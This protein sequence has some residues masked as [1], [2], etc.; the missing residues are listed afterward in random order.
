MEDEQTPTMSTRDPSALEC[1]SVCPV[2]V[3][4]YNERRRR[5]KLLGCGH[6][7][8]LHCLQEIAGGSGRGAR[9]SGVLCP[10]CRQATGLPGP[11]V[12][13]LPDNFAIIG[14][15]SGGSGGGPRGLCDTHQYEKM[16]FF[17]LPCHRSVS[18]HLS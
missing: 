4:G 14:F 18:R 6:T 2:C 11:G 1:V 16:K 15:I 10:V 3:Q 7:F 17:C 12:T 13:H 5:P 8:C 9:D